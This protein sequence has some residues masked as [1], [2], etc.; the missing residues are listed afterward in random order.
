MQE[1]FGG[2]GFSLKL[3]QSHMAD[4]KNDPVSGRQ[5]ALR[6]KW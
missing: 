1:G 4:V 5:F 6:G 3:L 2:L